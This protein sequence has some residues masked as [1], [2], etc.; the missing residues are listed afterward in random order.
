M[1]YGPPQN[2]QS[3]SSNHYDFQ[4]NPGARNHQEDRRKAPMFLVGG[5]G[6]PNSLTG[7]NQT[8]F[9]PRFAG[10]LLCLHF[11]LDLDK[12]LLINTEG[13]KAATCNASDG[14]TRSP[15]PLVRGRDSRMLVA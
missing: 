6:E 4:T 3:W 1:S 5:S 2:A 8:V 11:H 15:R 14:H 13:S 12:Q 9:R 7:G 10:G